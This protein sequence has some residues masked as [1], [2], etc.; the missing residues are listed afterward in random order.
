MFLRVSPNGPSKSFDPSPRDTF[1]SIPGNVRNREWRFL[2]FSSPEE[3][4]EREL[5]EEHRKE[6]DWRTW[7]KREGWINYMNL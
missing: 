5:E 6:E 2:S 3:E 7:G 1:P 4:V